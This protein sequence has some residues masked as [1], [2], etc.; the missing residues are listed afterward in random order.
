[1]IFEVLTASSMK[2]RV[3]YDLAPYS[4]AGVDRRFRRAYC[5]PHLGHND[6]RFTH[7]ST[8]GLLQR[9]RLHGAISQKT[10]IH[11]NENC[12][13]CLSELASIFFPFK[14]HFKNFD[15]RKIHLIAN[16]VPT[17]ITIYSAAVLAQTIPTSPL[18]SASIRK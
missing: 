3:F 15:M 14:C 16:S 17:F 9:D 13:R 8:V 6:G 1:V 5:V 18:D 10:H 2:M 12:L 11:K 7:D 4:L